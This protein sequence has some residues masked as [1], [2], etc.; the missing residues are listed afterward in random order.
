ML[1]SVDKEC[2]DVDVPGGMR[3]VYRAHDQSG[4]I[5]TPEGGPE[6][7]SVSMRAPGFSSFAEEVSSHKHI[8]TP[9]PPHPDPAGS[10]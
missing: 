1:L 9:H 3:N 6:G 2:D 10:N 8:L 7:G 4:E 5:F